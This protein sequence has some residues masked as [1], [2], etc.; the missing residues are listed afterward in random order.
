MSVVEVVAKGRRP[1]RPRAQKAKVMAVVKP[2]AKPR[3]S[4]PPPIRPPQRMRA[5]KV[6]RMTEGFDPEERLAARMK[7]RP[8]PYLKTLVY[9]ERYSGYRYPDGYN[10]KTATNQLILQQDMGYWPSASGASVEEPGSYYSV[11]RPSL[12]HP[13]WEY[14]AFPALQ[15]ANSGPA[16]NVNQQTDRFGI[17]ATAPGALDIAEQSDQMVLQTGVSY[18]VVMP[19]THPGDTFSQ[20]PYKSQNTDGTDVYGYTQAIGTGTA[21]YQVTLRTATPLQAGDT[22]TLSLQDTKGTAAVNIAAFTATAGQNVFTNTPV[23]VSGNAIW[24]TDTSGQGLGKAIGRPGAGFRLTY[25]NLGGAGLQSVALDSVSVNLQLSVPPTNYLGLHPTDFPDQQTLLDKLTLYRPVSSSAW[26]AY[27]GSTLNNGG[28]HACVMYRGG[29]HPNQAGLYN[30]DLISQ[31]PTSYEDKMKKGSYQ[32]WLPAS[33]RDTQM[34]L[35][36]N[37]NEWEH[38]YMAIAG[39]VGD[40]TQAN[41]LRMRGILNTEFVSNSQLFEYASVLPD[42]ASIDH[43]TEVL[44]DAPTSMANDDHLSA[45]YNWIKSR[46]GDVVNW[47]VRNR[48]WLVPLAKAGALVAGSLV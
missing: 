30:F 26:C 25:S 22:L 12:V 32:F 13:Y 14:G 43:A 17:K 4:R 34:R 46:V 18:N 3:R 9:P 47:G 1:R 2:P 21:K 42:Q 31:T 19:M 15:T 48:G 44:Q 28:Q 39:N 20:D 41:P 33:T 16:W 29:I 11:W 36:Q 8:N 38:P 35:P 23:D 6:V 45:I 40:L 27:Q 24:T 7:G 37:P 5:N 10:R